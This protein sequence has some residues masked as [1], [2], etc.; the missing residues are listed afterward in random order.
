ML[1][2]NIIDIHHVSGVDLYLSFQTK[3][4]SVN[5]IYGFHD[6]AL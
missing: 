4:K 1:V 6:Y 2:P 5:R 3:N